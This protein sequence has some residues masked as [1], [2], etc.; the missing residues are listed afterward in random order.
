ML[1][2]DVLV[3]YCAVLYFAVEDAL[4]LYCAV[5][6]CTSLYS[7]LLASLYPCASKAL[8]TSRRIV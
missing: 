5:L 1:D 3:L 4:V 6:Y 2:E 7:L 8:L